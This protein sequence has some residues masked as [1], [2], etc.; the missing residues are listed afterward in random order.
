[1]NISQ[2]T[3]AHSMYVPVVPDELTFPWL[4]V[5]MLLPVFNITVEDEL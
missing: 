2:T 5:P 4:I 3:V 1:M